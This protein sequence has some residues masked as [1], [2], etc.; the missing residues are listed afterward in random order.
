MSFFPDGIELSDIRSPSEILEEAQRD[1]EECSNG[2]LL[3]RISPATVEGEDELILDVYI[4]HSPSK[5]M[6]K[7]LSVA[8]RPDQPYPVEI[9][10]ESFD[11]PRYLKK[12]YTVQT[13]RPVSPLFSVT[14]Y[15]RAAERVMPDICTQTITN[16]WVCDTPAEFREKLQKALSLS[17]VKSAINNIIASSPLESLSSSSGF[18]HAPEDSSESQQ[19]LGDQDLDI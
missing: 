19:R 1:W 3:L 2:I 15:L 12:S 7:L 8:H 14:D 17:S 10:P 13:R 16:E 11:I 6:T 18:D 4:I 5:R 9:R